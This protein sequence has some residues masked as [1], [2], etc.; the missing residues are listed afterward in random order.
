MVVQCAECGTQGWNGQ[1]LRDYYGAPRVFL[2]D[3]L[4]ERFGEPH[5][6][7]FGYLTSSPALSFSTDLSGGSLIPQTITAAV[8]ISTTA[9]SLTLRTVGLGW[10]ARGCD[11]KGCAAQLCSA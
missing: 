7:G 5:E 10:P 11:G 8:G 4:K 9:L 1:M 6:L 2:L 3:L